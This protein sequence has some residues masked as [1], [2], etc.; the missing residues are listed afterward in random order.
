[1]CVAVFSVFSAVRFSLQS[2]DAAAQIGAVCSGSG[3]NGTVVSAG[4]LLY[5]TRKKKSRQCQSTMTVK[6]LSV[7]LGGTWVRPCARDSAS[8][9]AL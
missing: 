1:M 3:L 8:T 9:S 6:K 7:E 2:E 4:S 5:A